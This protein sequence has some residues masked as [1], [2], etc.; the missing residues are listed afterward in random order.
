MGITATEMASAPSASRA[1]RDLAVAAS[2]HRRRLADAVSAFLG[3]DR[4][5]G[6]RQRRRD[7]DSSAQ[8]ASRRLAEGDP[9][10][11]A[12]AVARRRRL[13]TTTRPSPQRHR[14]LDIRYLREKD[15]RDV[16]ASGLR[17]AAPSRLMQVRLVT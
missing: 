4:R 9:P 17:S 2:S 10:A 16:Q 12:E 1:G 14:S 8:A 3:D 5:L 7:D 15:H 13:Q 11:A 6:R